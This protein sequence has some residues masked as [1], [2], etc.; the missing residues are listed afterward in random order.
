MRSKTVIFTMISL[1][2]L[3]TIA[4]SGDKA[5]ATKQKDGKTEIIWHRFDDGMKLAKEQNKNVFVRFTTDWCGWCKKMN[6]TTFKESEIIEFIDKYYIAVSV[7]GESRDSL[8]LDG[9][10]TTE[11]QVTK[12]FGVRSYPTFWF[13]SP[14]NEKIAPIK[15]YR[16]K[17]GL[18]DVLDYLKD[19]AYKTTEFREFLAQKKKK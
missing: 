16:D 11:K 2:L 18:F 4:F 14:E 8:N 3:S 15:G 7:N 13:L 1:L 5:P 17:D 6:A 9:W 12:E 10:I 19:D